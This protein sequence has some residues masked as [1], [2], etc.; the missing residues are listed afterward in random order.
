M[1]KRTLICALLALTTAGGAGAAPKIKVQPRMNYFTE[2]DSVATVIITGDAQP[3]RAVL[4]D[5]DT[6]LTLTRR[7]PMLYTL[8]LTALREGDNMLRIRVNDS[9]YRV[10]L[11][12]LPYKDN[13]VQIDYLTG[14]LHTEG[15]P[16]VPSGVYC[17]SPVQPT[18]QEGEGARGM[19]LLSPYQNLGGQPR[20]ER[21]AYLE[22]PAHPCEEGT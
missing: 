6:P 14:V 7:S 5:S 10:R 15:L 1:K 20:K 19:T 2:R 11:T 17:Y 9:T 13:G 21:I 8:P 4:E 16:L 12:R 18:I 22:R 3:G